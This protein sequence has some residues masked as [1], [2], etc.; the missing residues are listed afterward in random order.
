MVK[1]IALLIGGVV[2]VLFSSV[3]SAQ[4]QEAQTH[5]PLVYS[6]QVKHLQSAVATPL[7]GVPPL[8]PIDQ[9]VVVN[10]NNGRGQ[11]FPGNVYPYP[12]V[13]LYRL[14]S[15]GIWQWMN[16][17]TNCFAP[18]PTVQPLE[19]QG[20]PDR[21]GNA[22]FTRDVNGQPL[23]RGQYMAAAEGQDYHVARSLPV[24]VP[25]APA[26]VSL[27]KRALSPDYS[28][29][30]MMSQGQSTRTIFDLIKEGRDVVDVT[31]KLTLRGVIEG[32]S[33]DE[34]ETRTLARQIS[35]FRTRI[36]EIFSV[37][38][39]ERGFSYCID[40]EMRNTQTNRFITRFGNCA[41]KPF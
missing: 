35:T 22:L 3:A 2:M 27:V 21:N 30:V 11:A 13:G 25:G 38:S 19:P 28:Q 24:A 10:V 7:P 23:L 34:V 14:A 29:S 8:P 36:D 9:V 20:C 1:R 41:D 37:Q 31:I 6:W 40:A 4:T 33:W 12:A 18:P 17:S 16:S 39:T 15:Y 32:E 5:A 26:S